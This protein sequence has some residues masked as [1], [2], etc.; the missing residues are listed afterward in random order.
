MALA[1]VPAA[2]EE[3]RHEPNTLHGRSDNRRANHPDLLGQASA[4]RQHTRDD[5]LGVAPTPFVIKPWNRQP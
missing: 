2:S 3:G 5:S 1:E 4:S